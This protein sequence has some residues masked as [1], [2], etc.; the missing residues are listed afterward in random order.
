MVRDA[1]NKLQV[2][3]DNDEDK[4]HTRLAKQYE[5]TSFVKAQHILFLDDI[6]RMIDLLVNIFA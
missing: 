3:V 2:Q 1:S 5:G 4:L 6:K